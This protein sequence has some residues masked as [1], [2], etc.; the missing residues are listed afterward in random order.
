MQ[1]GR[2]DDWGWY[3]W[4]VE[5]SSLYQ[6]GQYRVVA[7]VEGEA[8]ESVPFAVSGGAVLDQT[9]RSA[10]DFFFV[11]RCGFEVPGW[12]KAC[13]LDD[14]KLPDG[15][16]LDLTGG[17]HSAGDYNKLMYE[18]GDGGV[19]WALLYAHRSAPKCFARFDRRGD[20]WPD[21][22]DEA[23]WGAR[24]VAKMQIPEGGGLRQHVNQGPGR[25]WTKW[26]APE[27][28]TDNVIG[29]SDDPIVQPGEGNSPWVIGG[30]ARLSVLLGQ[31]GMT[32]DYLER[33]VRLWKHATKDGAQTGGPHLLFSTLELHTVTSNSAYLD[34]ARRSVSD[35][36]AQQI[37]TGPLRGAF[38]NYGELNAAALAQFALAYPDEPAVARITPAL[39]EYVT[40]CV[41]TADNPFGLSK[42]TLGE[43]ESFLPSDLGN[44]FQW[45]ARSWAAA[46]IYRLNGD[47]RALRYAVDHLDWVLGKNP[48]N[49][50]LLEGHGTVNPLRYHHRYNVIPGRERGAVP[51]TIPNG[52]VRDM[53]LA[54]RPGFDLS[55][56]GGRS[57]SF[58]TSEPWLVHNLFYLLAASE[59]YRALNGPQ[60]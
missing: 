53:G 15:T 29:T 5:F 37:Q 1:S 31:R 25:D 32:N 40:F 45:L 8:A 24:F 46:L 56:A 41:S 50:C 51:G 20:G 34:F 44:N 52:F 3:F 13:H 17:W 11:Q 9:A 58:R 6:A 14:A 49:L 23:R 10:V 7:Q 18:H 43:K 19:V 30:W 47:A 26:L 35:L 4:R 39:D 57:P 28:H 12:H 16:H 42:Q 21:A 60:L 48:L 2:P 33:A 54:D 36:L 22:I 38:G 55:R 59:L 27:L